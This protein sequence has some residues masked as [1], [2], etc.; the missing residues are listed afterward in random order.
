MW[1]T[2]VQRFLVS[3]KFG[4]NN[5]KRMA[6][7]FSYISAIPP[8]WSGGQLSPLQ[9]TLLFSLSNKYLKAL[10]SMHNRSLPLKPTLI[11]QHCWPLIKPPTYTYTASVSSIPPHIPTL[12]TSHLSLR[13]YLHSLHLIYPLTYNNTAGVSLTPPHI[14]TLPTSHLFPHIYLHCLHVIYPPNSTAKSSSR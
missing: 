1:S 3:P 14:P 6:L 8:G 5:Y 9:N 11:F 2:K 4:K 10:P 7:F 12:P 13:I